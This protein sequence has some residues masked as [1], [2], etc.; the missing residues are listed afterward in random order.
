MKCFII[1]PFRPEFDEVVT[2]V[3][4]ALAQAGIDEAVR[5]DDIMGAGYISPELQGELQAA[6]FC[7]ADLSDLNPNV[8]WETG[9]AAALL[10]PTI[11][12]TRSQD[13][14]PFDVHDLRFERYD[15]KNL[16]TL[17]GRLVSAIAHTLRRYQLRRIQ[18]PPRTA[19]TIAITGSMMAMPERVN[20][21]LETLLPPYLSTD[22]TW[23]CGT[24]GNTD[25]TAARY[26]LERKQRV[27]GVGYAQLDVSSRMLKILEE[28]HA[29]FV[30]ASREQL[31]KV[32][33]APTPRDVLFA[34][35]ADLVILLW[36]GQSKGIRQIS[37]WLTEQGKSHLLGVA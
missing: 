13:P 2:V 3:K 19:T 24:A 33:G 10:K 35:K 4:A 7:I 6:D 32:P 23:Y 27:I 29:P 37:E 1:M 22:T 31:L 21:R 9:Y 25:E 30:D 14:L 16:P 34:Q 26:L 12:I 11:A 15:P 18:L 36:D 28:F 17:H 20:R 5:M 8:M